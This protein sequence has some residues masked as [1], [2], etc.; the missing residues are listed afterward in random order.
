M[1]GE[2]G[3]G[4]GAGAWPGSRSRAERFLSFGQGPVSR[5]LRAGR[6]PARAMG[7]LGI[8][9]ALPLK[10]LTTFSCSAERRCLSAGQCKSRGGP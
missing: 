4:G 5:C 6:S 7:P 10:K 2:R 9:A 3:R 1:A 8:S